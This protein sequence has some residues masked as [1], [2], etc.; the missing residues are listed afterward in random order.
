MINGGIAAV[1]LLYAAAAHAQPFH[2]LEE[3]PVFLNTRLD[4]RIV[5]LEALIVKPKDD[6]S[7][8]PV[9]LIAHGKAPVRTEMNELSPGSMRAVARDLAERGWLSVI[10][11]R[12]GFGKSD[13]PF[14]G[15]T[16]C[17]SIKTYDQ[18]SLDA[19]ELAASLD[20]IRQRPDADASRIIAIGASAGGAAVVALA[21]K[22]PAGL[23]AVVNL[24][25]GLDYENCRDAGQSN[26]VEAMGKL[27]K[28][29]KVS[30][31][32]IY[33]DN[34]R[35]FP[36][37][38]VNRMHEAALDAGADIR[39]VSIAK[40]EPDG[41]NLFLA[42]I[43]RRFWL[44]ELDQSLR[45]WSLPTFST[46]VVEEWMKATGI[47]ERN[48]FDVY[49]SAPGFKAFAYSTSGKTF[50]YRFGA[51]TLKGAAE[52]SLK[53]CEAKAKDCKVVLEGMKL[54]SSN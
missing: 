38:L 52:S 35:L 51:G 40:L 37:T 29:S 13:G 33:A 17:T 48:T 34:D 5:R 31:L 44:R 7:K 3:T 47:K 16:G 8:R 26:L 25:G 43:G 39:R 9:A 22:A 11:M 54:T 10:V 50:F 6:A 14:L 2:E 15:V 32:W 20:V 4:G 53:D 36:A 49:A 24:S 42:S 18:F 30:Q 27:G 28:E 45:Q 41:H 46:S 19:Q 1:A 23:K 12:R 21:A